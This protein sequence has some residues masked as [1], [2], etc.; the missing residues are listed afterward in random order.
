MRNKHIALLIGASALAILALIGF[1]V[2]WMLHSRGLIEEQFNNRVNMALCS[3]VERI[4]ED[5]VCS[6]QIRACCKVG[7]A[8]GTC[9]E[10]IESFASMPE[11]EKVLAAALR[12]YQIDLPYSIQVTAKD[13]N[14]PPNKLPPFSCS[15]NPV[16]ENDTH[17]LQVQFEGKTNYLLQKMGMMAGASIVIL[18]LICL[19]FALA[20][21]YLL[22]QQKMSALNRDFFNHMTHEFRTP[23]TNIKLAGNLLARKHPELQNNQ[24]LNIIQQESR[25]LMGHVEGVLHLAALE[26]GDYRLQKE[27]VDLRQMLDNVVSGMEL[28]IKEKAGQVQWEGDY[29]DCR[30]QGDVFHLTNAFRN[31]LDN[32]LK[33]NPSAPLIHIGL[34]PGPAG[35]HILFQDNGVG[36]SEKECQVVFDKFQRATD[37]A[38]AHHSGFGLGLAY[39]KK[40]VDMHRGQISLHSEKGWGTR[41]DLYLPVA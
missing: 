21:Y 30:V 16:L 5:Q 17:L 10:T 1:Q 12:Y 23:L 36:M 20:S 40:I 27:T 26:K 9:T 34:K 6:E 39:V 25:Q 8:E 14:A 24:Y 2:S 19:V 7:S 29:Q 32:A 35:W 31:L 22:R 18:C 37:P 33:Y 4:A 13:T 38:C 41:F 28:Q 15:L 3:T 11:T